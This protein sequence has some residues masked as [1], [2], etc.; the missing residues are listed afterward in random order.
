M[1]AMAAIAPSAQ[2]PWL[3]GRASDLLLGAGLIYVPVFAALAL[4]GNAIQAALP[5]TLMP[6]LM[7]AINGPHVGATLLRVYEREE[8]RR[9]YRL[10]AVHA[11]VLI[12]ALFAAGLYVPLLG[13]LLITLYLSVVPWHF[14]GQN[15]GIALIFLRR[16]GVPIAREHKALLYFSFVATYAMTLI[17]LQTEGIRTIAP[18]DPSGTVYRLLRIGIPSSLSHGLLVLL[19]SAYVTALVRLGIGLSRVAPP[20]DLLP[21]AAVILSQALWLVVPL[22][23]QMLAQPG[24]FAPFALE[25]YAYTGLWIALAHAAQYLWITTYYARRQGGG[26]AAAPFLGKALLAGSALYGVPLLLLLPG[27]LGTLPYDAGLYTMVS[28]ALNLHHV[29]LDGAIWKL[30][31]GPIARILIQGAEE[32]RPRAHTPPRRVARWIGIGALASGLLGAALTVLSTFEF[33]FGY[34]RA[35]RRGD[36]ARLERAVTALHWLGR[37]NAEAR[38]EV[39]RLR[40]ARG[41]LDGSIAALEES[42]GLLPTASQYLRL[43]ALRERRGEPEAALLAYERAVELAPDF[44]PALRRAGRAS[45]DAGRPTRARQL[46]ERAEAL[47]PGGAEI[48]AELE[49][50]RGMQAGGPS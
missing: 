41:D 47:S 16:R 1:G 6:L 22:V 13:S 4:A 24:A 30:R 27:A 15:Y 31:N 10:F 37:D 3:H 17:A 50:A 36:L 33:E 34:L 29:L 19:G 42:I 11:T 44:V 38:G 43:G 21:A 48:G 14:T 9:R 5:F 40:L 18:V 28:G 8:D 20:R 12:A 23:V 39:A 46:L 49:R 26:E 32:S 45:L 35:A 25:N 2:T 7:V